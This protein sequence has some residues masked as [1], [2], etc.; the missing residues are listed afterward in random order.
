[1]TPNEAKRKASCAEQLANNLTLEAIEIIAKKA[2]EKDMSKKII[3]H[4]NLL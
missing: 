3:R 4:Q 2:V 1:M